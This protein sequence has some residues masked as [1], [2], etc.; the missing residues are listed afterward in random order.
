M[1]LSLQGQL[2]CSYQ[3]AGLNFSV[4]KDDISVLS[5]L[6]FKSYVKTA[7]QKTGNAHNPTLTL[8]TDQVK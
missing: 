7:M 2:D 6:P 1:S 4:E 5:K 3:K 8:I